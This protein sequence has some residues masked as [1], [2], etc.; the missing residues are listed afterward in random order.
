MKLTL[1]PESSYRLSLFPIIGEESNALIDDEGFDA[2]V[3]S[4]L[5]EKYTEQ[6]ERQYDI[7]FDFY[8]SGN[9]MYYSIDDGD[10]DELEDN[11]LPIESKYSLDV[12]EIEPDEDFQLVEDMQMVEDCG[13]S[14]SEEIFNDV[15]NLHNDEEGGYDIIVEA[16]RRRMKQIAQQLVEEGKVE[17]AESVRFTLQYGELYGC[18]YSFDMEAEEFDPNALRQIDCTDWNDCDGSEVLQDHWPDRLV[19]NIVYK[20]KFYAG[21]CENVDS[22]SWNC[23]LVDSDLNSLL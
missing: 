21:E 15:K 16:I 10:Q 17:D 6:T 23:D 20:G 7:I 12:N 14:D 9:G 11:V 5:E 3:L 2:D 4:E 13:N 8:A 22:F 19:G 1:F 18:S